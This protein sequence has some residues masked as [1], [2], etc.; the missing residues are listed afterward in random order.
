MILPNGEVRTSN[1]TEPLIITSPRWRAHFTEW[2]VEL[3]L[4]RGALFV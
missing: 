1:F 4:G 2:L 3:D